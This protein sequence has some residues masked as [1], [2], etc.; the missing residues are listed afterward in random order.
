MTAP[1][2]VFF[3]EDPDTSDYY[4]LKGYTYR[5]MGQPQVA[6]V[7]FD[8]ARVRLERALLAAPNSAPRLSSLANV[9]AGLGRVDEA[10]SM[11]R[12]AID[13][14]PVSADALDGPN[15]IRTLVMV[16]AQTGQQDEAIDLVAYLLTIPSNL[17]VNALKLMPE[18]APL[19]DHPRFQALL[20]KYEK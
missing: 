6:K 3:P 1:G 18:F 5:L 15:C 16:Y 17:S 19:R 12:R 14:V 11:A 7:Y 10:L 8:S 20:K 9:Y 2:D 4:S 13:L